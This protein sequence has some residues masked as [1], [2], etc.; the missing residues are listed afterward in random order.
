MDVTY[1]ERRLAISV[2]LMNAATDPSA[3]RAHGGMVDA[4]R[5]L[6]RGK[7]RGIAQIWP[8]AAFASL[9]DR[10]EDALAR[11]ADDGGPCREAR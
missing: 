8:Q 11:W 2:V 10:V 4:Y 9:P 5:A 7:R 6:I 3:R 1:F